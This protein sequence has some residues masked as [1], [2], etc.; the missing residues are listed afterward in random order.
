MKKKLV[1]DGDILVYT[2]TSAVEQEID[3][4]EDI[5]VLW[6]DLGDAKEKAEDMLAAEPS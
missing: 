4:G 3:W 6:S 5:W 2:A 1:I